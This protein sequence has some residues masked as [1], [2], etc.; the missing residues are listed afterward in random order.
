MLKAIH[1]HLSFMLYLGRIFGEITTRKNVL[2]LISVVLQTDLLQLAD[3][4][5]WHLQ[6]G[7][8]GCAHPPYPKLLLME[9]LREGDRQRNAQL[10][11]S[12]IT[13]TQLFLFQPPISLLCLIHVD[14][15]FNLP[16]SLSLS[17]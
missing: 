13:S 7:V 8:F 1:F 10:T 2:E 14:V 6:K 15:C 3:T 4:F 12:T 9:P 17:V 11:V 5:V 16:L